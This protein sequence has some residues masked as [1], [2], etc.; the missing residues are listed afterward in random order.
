MNILFFLTPKSEVAY[1]Y[2]TDSVRITLNL[3]NGERKLLRIY[4]VPTTV[5]ESVLKNVENVNIS[6]M[7]K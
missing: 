3:K 1:I 2:D 5:I 6:M 4:S 7:Q